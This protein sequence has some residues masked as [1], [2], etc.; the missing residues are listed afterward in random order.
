MD[1]DDD[2]VL[3]ASDPTRLESPAKAKRKA[4]EQKLK[5]AGIVLQASGPFKD[6]NKLKLSV[7]KNQFAGKSDEEQ[8]RD[9]QNK[10]RQNQK[11]FGTKTREQQ[12]KADQLTAV[13]VASVDQSVQQEK[14]A[15]AAKEEQQEQEIQ[16]EDA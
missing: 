1:Y 6:A 4:L 9:D 3:S 13:T 8:K 11:S 12:I 16:G 2:S 5:K 7:L 14:Q 10:D 15:V